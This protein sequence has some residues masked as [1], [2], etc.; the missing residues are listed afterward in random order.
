MELLRY[1]PHMNTEKLK[2]N[3]FFF[4]LNVIIHAKVRI[5][6]PQML[7]DAV[8]K[9][10]ID[11]EELISGCQGR[12]PVRPTRDATSGVKKHQTPAR[13]LVQNN[14][15]HNLNIHLVQSIIR[16]QLDIHLVPKVSSYDNTMIDV[17]VVES[18]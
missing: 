3:K 2:V 10:L 17:S 6:M 13:H 14:M 7:H 5:I 4:G 9:A 16:H 12:K 8:Q 18:L 1:A 15:R 11:E